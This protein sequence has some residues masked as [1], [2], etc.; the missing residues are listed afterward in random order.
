[1]RTVLGTQ[2]GTL[3]SPLTGPSF[4]VTAACNVPSH[5]RHPSWWP[6][7]TQLQASLRYGATVGSDASD[8][9]RAV[10]TR[11]G[12]G[13]NGEDV[14]AR[15]PGRKVHR[16]QPHPSHSHEPYQ[17]TC[18]LSLA[19]RACH[20]PPGFHRSPC[21]MTLHKASTLILFAASI[22]AAA[23][24]SAAHPTVAMPAVPVTSSA[25]Q[26]MAAARSDA[27][28][29]QGVALASVL[30]DDMP[31]L[32]TADLFK[33][34]KACAN[35]AVP[36]QMPAHSLSAVRQMQYCVRCKNACNFAFDVTAVLKRPVHEL[37]R[38]RIVTTRCG[39]RLKKLM[40]DGK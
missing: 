30:R 33:A 28:A 17:F 20:R 31:A 15:S 21:T 22:V 29:N 27:T 26:P 2:R 10:G 36:C 11:G 8:H 25:A 24:L 18:F 14:L 5:G 34:V 3:E 13:S 1:M 32:T 38:W 12:E 16:A 39:L 19:L 23:M 7:R 37:K 6:Q 40:K 4:S 35:V 9:W